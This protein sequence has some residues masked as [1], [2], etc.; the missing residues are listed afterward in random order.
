MACLVII[1]FNRADFASV[2]IYNIYIIVN[3]FNRNILFRNKINDK[4]TT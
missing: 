2:I 4:E 3:M 1:F